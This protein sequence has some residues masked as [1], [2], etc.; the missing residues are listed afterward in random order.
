MPE[1]GGRGAENEVKCSK[2]AD[3]TQPR[4]FLLDT[5]IYG[6][7]VVDVDIELLKSEYERCRVIILI[8]GINE[9]IRKELRATPKHIKVGNR[10]LRSNLL[11]LYDAF[12]GNH[13]LSLKEEHKKLAD[14][15]YLA[16]RHFGGSKTKDSVFNDFLIVACAALNGM[17]VV[18]SEDEKTMLAENAIKAYGFVNDLSKKRT[19]RFIGYKGFKLELRSCSSNKF[20]G[21]P[22]KFG[23]F[24]VFLYFLNQLVKINLFLF[25]RPVSRHATIKNFLLFPEISLKRCHTN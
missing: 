23:V 11:G 16:Y 21:S 7:M 9:V 5:N 18:V 1:E 17:D 13:G 6:E 14:A 12:T 8:Y 20:V 19:P 3:K 15:Y 24:L 2:M 10:K 22:D 25:H 4:K